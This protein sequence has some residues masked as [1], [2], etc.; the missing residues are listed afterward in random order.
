[1]FFATTASAVVA[2]ATAD[3]GRAAAFAAALAMAAGVSTSDFSFALVGSGGSRVLR[4]RGLRLLRG[5]LALGLVGI[6]VG[7]VGI[8]VAGG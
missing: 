4:E 2:D 3:G 8:G 6:G 7:F 1:V 5:A